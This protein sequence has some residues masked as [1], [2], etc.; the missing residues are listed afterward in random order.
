MYTYVE[1]RFSIHNTGGLCPVCDGTFPFVN[2]I[3]QVLSHKMNEQVVGCA[4]MWAA[5][6]EQVKISMRKFGF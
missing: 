5:A 4:V 3:T 1:S 6:E 2:K